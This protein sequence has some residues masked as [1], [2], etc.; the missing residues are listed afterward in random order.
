M[1]VGK[2]TISFYIEDEG[3]GSRSLPVAEVKERRLFLNFWLIHQYVQHGIY[4]FYVSVSCGL[5]DTHTDRLTA[6]CTLANSSS[7][8]SSVLC[9]ERKPSTDI[10]VVSKKW[11]NLFKDLERRMR[12]N[13]LRSTQ[14]TKMWGFNTHCHCAPAM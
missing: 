12:R 7:L 14:P 6:S 8:V 4:S 11:V 3:Q 2:T 13:S 1:R 5:V 10:I 9:T